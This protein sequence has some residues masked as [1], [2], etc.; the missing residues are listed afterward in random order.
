M[1][2]KNTNEMSQTDVRN[3]IR[4]YGR[5]KSGVM[6]GRKQVYFTTCTVCGKEILSTTPKEEIIGASI[7]KRGG[8]V[9]WHSKCE[10]KVWNSKIR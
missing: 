5:V 8:A 6:D 9:F 10:G 2:D 4:K 7:N 1:E 3:A